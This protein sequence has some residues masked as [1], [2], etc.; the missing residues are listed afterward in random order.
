MGTY[1]TILCL[2]L[3]AAP[4]AATAQQVIESIAAKI[5]DTTVITYSDILQEAALLNLENGAP[6]HTPLSRELKEK[7][8]DSLILRAILF[9]ESRDRDLPLD[10]RTVQEM[11]ATYEKLPYLGDL[12]KSFGISP[13]EFRM[14]VKKRLIVRLM[15]DDLLKRRFAPPTKPSEEEKKKAL[16]EWFDSLRKKHRIITYAIP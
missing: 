7:I 13:L 15:M 14:I 4:V 3:L 9:F 1:R 5:D 2:I 8:L 6:L 16:D 11:V 12:F 10:D